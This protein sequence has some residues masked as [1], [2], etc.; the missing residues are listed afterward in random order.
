MVTPQ[1]SYLPSQQ[2][3]AGQFYPSSKNPNA[4][5][6]QVFNSAGQCIWRITA[7][8]TFVSGVQSAP[9]TVDTNSTVTPTN[10]N[11]Y[12]SGGPASG[13]QITLQTSGL[14][15]SSGYPCQN[16]FVYNESGIGPATITGQTGTINGAAS[17]TLQVGQCASFVFNGSTTA[18]NFTAALA[19][20]A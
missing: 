6:I 20:Q 9:I 13:L 7:A 11:V 3:I 15:S 14:T 19:T 10:P 5:I 18:P 2:A 16:Y 17:F 1:A 12:L 4:D 8:G